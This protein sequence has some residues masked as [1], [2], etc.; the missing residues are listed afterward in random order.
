MKKLWSAAVACPFCGG[1]DIWV[2]SVFG[3]WRINKVVFCRDCTSRGPTSDNTKKATD[4][5]N[6]RGME[7]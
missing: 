7:E 1:V 2:E 4:S 6:Y 5:W 3:L